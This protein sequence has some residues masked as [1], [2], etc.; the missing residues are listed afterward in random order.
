LPPRPETKVI[1]V[2]VADLTLG[3]VLLGSSS[4]GVFERLFGGLMVVGAVKTWGTY[5]R[6]RDRYESWRKRYRR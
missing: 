2:T 5:W 4:F 6:A 3:A 1:L